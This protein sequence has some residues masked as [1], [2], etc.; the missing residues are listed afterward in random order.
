MLMVEFTKAYVQYCIVSAH[1]SLIP[2]KSSRDEL[3]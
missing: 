1:E 3:S 2:S